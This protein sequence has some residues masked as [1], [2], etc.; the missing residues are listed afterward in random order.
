MPR[1]KEITSLKLLSTSVSPKTV[2]RS[3]SRPRNTLQS[4]STQNISSFYQDTSKGSC[5]LT[6]LAGLILALF[7]GRLLVCFLPAHGIVGRVA[8]CPGGLVGVPAGE[9]ALA[10]FLK[11]L[12]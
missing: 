2:N 5:F 11:G 8:V 4:L 1:F 6:S 7:E 12:K 9:E 3:N 10:V